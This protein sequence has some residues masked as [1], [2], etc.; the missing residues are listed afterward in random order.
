M[1]TQTKVF[2]ELSDIIG[3]RLQCK[4]CGCALSLGEAGSTVDSLLAMNNVVLLKCPA[5]PQTWMEAPDRQKLADTEL[6][7][8]ARKFRDFLKL[9]G[10]YGCTLSL[11]IKQE[12]P[13]EDE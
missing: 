4:A 8:L 5:C 10:R 6:K 3:L 9:E 7:E 12:D 1:T 2:I 13:E 11:E